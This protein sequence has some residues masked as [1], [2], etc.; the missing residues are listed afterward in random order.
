MQVLRVAYADS[1]G[2]GS[3]MSSS[4]TVSTSLDMSGRT[5]PAAR[6]GLPFVVTW[7]V[8]MP[9]LLSQS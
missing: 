9:H 6:T 7:S 1:D 5:F 8:F 4:A 2:A 3:R